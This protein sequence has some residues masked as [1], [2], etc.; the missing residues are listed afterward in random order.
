MQP[1]SSNIMAVNET[2][3]GIDL[4]TTFSAIAYLDNEGR[5]VTLANSEG[6]LTTPSVVFFDDDTVIVGSEAAF[7]GESDFSRLARAA[8]RDMGG[9]KFRKPVLGRNLPAEVI[10][11]FV[12]H[13]LKNDAELKLGPISKAVITVPAYFNEPRRKATQDAGELAGLE[14]IDIINEPTAAALAYGVQRGFLNQKG[15]AFQPEVVLVYDLGGGTFDVTL[16]EIV[17]SQFNTIATAGDVYLGGIDW[18]QRLFEFAKSE[19]ESKHSCRLDDDSSFNER[20]LSQCVRAKKSLTARNETVI[21]VEHAGERYSVPV[22]RSQFEELTADL[23]ER[24]R[25]TTEKLLRNAMI[26][27]TDLTKLILVG[28]STRMPMVLNMLESYSG[29]QLDRTLSPDEAVA[30]GAAIYAGILLKHGGNVLSGLSI[31]NVN[32]HDLGVMGIDPDT[33][34]P[35]RKVLI[36]HN[37]RL[38]ANATKKFQTSKDGQQKVVVQI[39]EGGTDEGYGATTIGKCVVS[40]LPSDIPK[41]TEVVVSF[42]Y[43]TAGRLEVNANIPS[44]KLSAASTIERSS[45]M[46]SADIQGWKE[47]LKLGAEFLQREPVA[48]DSHTATTTPLTAPTTP[49]RELQEPRRE[50]KQPAAAKPKAITNPPAKQL[51]WAQPKVQSEP[52]T[53]ELSP[54]PKKVPPQPVVASK[55]NVLDRFEV[56]ENSGIFVFGDEDPKPVVGASILGILR[57]NAESPEKS[58]VVESALDFLAAEQKAPDAGISALDFLDIETDKRASESDAALNDFLNDLKNQ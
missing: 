34:Q 53:D 55:E 45:G 13:R 50:T 48:D 17:E 39:V 47:K 8:K 51:Q 24:T 44:L 3:I 15:A 43:S 46:S 54:T 38:P 9:G 29:V 18:D 36:P 19:I 6:E 32:S 10:Q 41:G 28:G 37:Y 42:N 25:M 16:M 12:L 26:E 14:V 27:W 56:D 4:G 52:T 7:A 40:G 33:R 23:L 31:A 49:K 57:N 20:L 1:D 35:R 21:R 2:P 30:H 11:S 22:T 5:P 58:A